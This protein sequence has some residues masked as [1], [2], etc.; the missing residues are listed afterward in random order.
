MADFK[1][2]MDRVARRTHSLDASTSQKPLYAAVIDGG[3][4]TG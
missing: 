2:E 1:P 4:G 3:G